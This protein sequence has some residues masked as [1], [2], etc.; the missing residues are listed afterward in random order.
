[1]CILLITHT[2]L[3]FDYAK[4]NEIIVDTYYESLV[5]REL[6]KDKMVTNKGIIKDNVFVQ[7]TRTH[8]KYYSVVMYH[9]YWSNELCSGIGR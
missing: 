2:I 1:M 4:I 6:C 9:Q 3:K 8:K 7:I 5:I